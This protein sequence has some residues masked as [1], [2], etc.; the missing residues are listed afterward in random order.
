MT[1]TLATRLSPIPSVQPAYQT[2]DPTIY[3]SCLILQGWTSISL[4]RIP[5]SSDPPPSPIPLPI[6][7]TRQSHL[8]PITTLALPC[9]IAYL[10]SM[11]NPLPISQPLKN[12][13]SSPPPAPLSLTRSWPT[14]PRVRVEECAAHERHAGSHPSLAEGYICTSRSSR[15][16]ATP[17]PLTPPPPACSQP[18]HARCLPTHGWVA[19]SFGRRR[20]IASGRSDP[21]PG[22]TLNVLSSTS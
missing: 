12:H 10:R 17:H 4:G 18:P 6:T 2:P 8:C 5:E 15:I 7:P 22:P 14:T 13:L 11:R 3:L 20:L 19:D 16:A 21:G 1:F 9:S